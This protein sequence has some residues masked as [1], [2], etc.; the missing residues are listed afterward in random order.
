LVFGGTGAASDLT[1]PSI[2]IGC[3]NFHVDTF[4]LK[5]PLFLDG[6]SLFQFQNSMYAWGGM[7]FDRKVIKLIS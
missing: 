3:D 2:K 1:V 6:F 4:H 7:N 5:R